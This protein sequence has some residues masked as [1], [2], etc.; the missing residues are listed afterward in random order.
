MVLVVWLL[1]LVAFF[2]KEQIGFYLYSTDIED[3]GRDYE[4]HIYTDGKYLSLKIMDCG[5]NA[6]GLTQSEI[7]E[8]LFEGNLPAFSKY[9]EWEKY[10]EVQL[11]QTFE[12]SLV[13]QEVL[14][15]ELKSGIVTMVFER[16][17]A[18]TV[19]M[20][21]TLNEDIVPLLDTTTVKQKRNPKPDVLA[22]WDTEADGWRSFRFDSIKSGSV[23]RA[24]YRNNRWLTIFTNTV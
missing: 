2:R 16:V 24:L 3:C 10:G 7:Y 6:F 11:N 18:R 14:K 19:L 5:V 13:G 12:N 4:Y 15:Q 21:C 22:L 9:C 23:S 20:K 8:P 17:M 1:R